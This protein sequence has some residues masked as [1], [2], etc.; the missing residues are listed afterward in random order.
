MA[1]DSSADDSFGNS[2]RWHIISPNYPQNHPLD[3]LSFEWDYYMIHDKNSGFY[4][5]LGYLVSNPRG[6]LKNVARLLPDGGNVAFIGF[7]NGKTTQANFINFGSQITLPS[8]NDFSLFLGDAV[9]GN[10]AV[11]TNLPTGSPEGKPAMLLEGRTSDFQWDSLVWQDWS[12]RE[13]PTPRAVVGKDIG[14]LP[15]EVW[16]VDALWP[17]TRVRGTVIHRQTNQQFNIDAHGYREN[18]WGRYNVISDG[19]DFYVF[20]EDAADLAAKGQREG[21]SVVV[22]TYHKSRELDFADV[23]FVD[24]DHAVSQRFFGKNGE[25]K[26]KHTGWFWSEK[27]NQCVPAKTDVVLENSSY[28]VRIAASMPEHRQATLLSRVT[29]PVSLYFIQNLFPEYQGEIIEKSTGKI[30]ATFS[31]A[32][33]AE[34]SYPKSPSPIP[35]SSDACRIWGKAFDR[36]FSQK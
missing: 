12:E 2:Q 31:G 15:G 28:M 11:S 14:V 18:S 27:A 30:V 6:R 3:V 5:I 24:G 26:L 21:V 16:T 17:R 20:S 19:W 13:L 9:A 23:G 22:Q 10:Y 36:F 1:S 33:A 29:F 8:L 7:M 25:M 35:L 4:G 34:F 32:G